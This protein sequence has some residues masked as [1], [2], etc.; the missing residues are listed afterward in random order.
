MKYTYTFR[1]GEQYISFR[2]S[3]CGATLEEMSKEIYQQLPDVPSRHHT[4][5]YD[6]IQKIRGPNAKN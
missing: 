2:P 5:I 4:W 1:L 6:E 3:Y